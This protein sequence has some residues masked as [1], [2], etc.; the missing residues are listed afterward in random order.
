MKNKMKV[1]Y[2]P[3]M[4]VD[5][6]SNVYSPSSKKPVQ[7]VESWETLGI[8]L[9]MRE[10]E[11]VTRE[12]LYR[13]HD[14]DYVDGVL[15]YRFQNGFGTIDRKVS[16]SLPYTSGAMLSAT[17][18]AIKEGG[19][20]CAP[21][22]GFHHA[23]FMGGGGFCTFNGLMLSAVEVVRDGEAECVGILDCDHH[24]GDGT[25]DILR[26]LS[27]E[28]RA[29]IVHWTVGGHK[30]H[31]RGRGQAF[32]ECLPSVIESMREEGVQVIIYQAGADPHIEDPLGGFLTTEELRLRD[33]IVF[34][35]CIKAE[36]PVAWCL[37]GGYQICKETGSIRKVLDIHDNTAIEMMSAL[38]LVG[39]S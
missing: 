15:D 18:A 35:E 14:Q 38:N 34:R 10:P 13:V 9:D 2:T 25:D 37:A 30:F 23:G 3:K 24:Y 29:D 17:R 32:L 1:Y 21:V 12:Q 22:S 33:K 20:V 7:V 11:P 39:A 26:R 28:Y 16:A 5:A 8:P 27:P 19:I 31:P 4:V 6:G 36:I